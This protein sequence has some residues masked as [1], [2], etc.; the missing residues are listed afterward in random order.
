M[1]GYFNIIAIFDDIVMMIKV[2]RQ[3]YLFFIAFLTTYSYSFSQKS[4]T[5]IVYSST[6]SEPLVGVT[7]MV[8]DKNVGSIS[9]IDGS[10]SL[11]LPEDDE[12]ITASFVGFVTQDITIGNQ[13]MISIYLEE[14]ITQLGEVVVTA[15]GFKEERDKLGLTA[16]KVEGDQISRSAET[17]LINGMAGKASGLRVTRSSGD[18]GAGSHIQIRGPVT[19]TSSLQPLIILDGVP[20]DNSTGSSATSGVVSQSRLNDINPNDIES[21]QILKGAS[22][23]ALWGSQAAKGVIYIT[24]KSGEKGQRPKISFRSVYSVDQI[25]S[26]HP[27]QNTFGQGDN[28]SFNPNSTRSW[29]DKLSE[30][31]GSE[32]IVD[33]FGPYFIDQNGIRHYN[34]LLKND[35]TIYDESNFNQIIKNGSYTENTLSISGGGENGTNY[36]SVGDL[37]Q[38]GIIRS[39]SNYRRTTVRFNSTKDLGN[40]LKITFKNSYSKTVSDR[41]RKGASSTGLY[42]GLLRT[43][44]DFDNTGYIGDYYLSSSSSPIQG[45]HRS[46]RNPTGGRVNAGFNNPN[47]TINNQENKN[48]VERFL[49]N[50]QFD[51]NITDWLN[52][53]SRT[54]IDYYQSRTVQYYKPG[55]VGSTFGQGY[56]TDGIANNR[57]FNTDIIARSNFE[58]GDD[59]DLSVTLGANLNDRKYLR[60]GGDIRDFIL[61]IDLQDFS[62]AQPENTNVDDFDRQM[63]TAATYFSGNIGL[64]DMLFLNSNVRVESSST[65]GPNA[66]SVFVYPSVDLAWQFSKLDLF[67]GSPILTFGKLR[68]AYGEVGVEPPPYNTQSIYVSPNYSDSYGGSLSTDLFGAGSFTPSQDLGDPNLR[69]EIKREYEVGTDIRFFD[70]KVKIGYSYYY[71]TTDDVFFNLSLANSSGYDELFTNAGKIENKGMEVDFSYDIIQN[72]DFNVNI[73]ANWSYYRNKVLDLKGVE[74]IRLGGLSAVSG[75]AVEGYPLGVFWGTKFTRSDDGSILLNDNG[76]PSLAPENGVIGDPHPDWQGGIGTTVTWKDLNLYFLFE[77]YQGA[78]IY[79]GTKAVLLNYGRHIESGTETTA[80]MDLFDYN[81]GLIT[82]GSTFRGSIHDFG[83]GDVALTE[84]WYRGIGGYFSGVQEQFIEDGSWTRLREVTL[85][86]SIRGPS[87][88]K[89]TKLSSIDLSITGRNLHIW[90]NFV[91]NDPDTNLTEVSTTRGIDYFNNP[92]TKSFVFK[93]TLNY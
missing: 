17:G 33:T 35:R 64:F 74:S 73:N 6:D 5:G 51:L 49:T 79:A 26:R 31:D 1:L 20:I 71:N 89:S 2:I 85:S 4:I 30:R 47:W 29:G 58:I 83:A 62:N 44:A 88:R 65:I 66:E 37:N 28:G 27:L 19:I 92:G 11:N 77:S 69:P 61:P 10:F 67:V 7:I 16:S 76:F 36:F 80:N 50:I 38:K 70:N 39:N 46:Y 14:D 34:V 32:D 48:S 53:I 40:W 78:D 59:I 18:P 91:G 90:T 43:P 86:Y 24:T 81:G 3:F 8:K 57:V 72:D 45:R 23:A 60:L 82:S 68:L 15:L 25:N 9:S 21:I 75:R 13:S 56:F 42:L 93:I 54:G 84:S 55:T 41:I 87:F 63:R 52:I 22:A 12:V